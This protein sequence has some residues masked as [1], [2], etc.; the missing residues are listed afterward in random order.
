MSKEEGKGGGRKGKGLEA[1]QG[2]G[3]SDRYLPRKE[4]VGRKFNGF[5][6]TLEK[7]GGGGKKL[8]SVSKKKSPSHL[9]RKKKEYVE[10]LY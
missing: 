3:Q 9:D 4:T 1:F 6:A 5:N 7:E 2:G 10:P 8:Y